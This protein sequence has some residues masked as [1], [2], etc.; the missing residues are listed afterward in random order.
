MTRVNSILYLNFIYRTCSVVT[1][2]YDKSWR[3]W[4]Y[5]YGHLYH[6]RVAI[7]STN[8]LQH[9]SILIPFLFFFFPRRE[10]LSRDRVPPPCLRAKNERTNACTEKNRRESFARGQWEFFQGR[11]REKDVFRHSIGLISLAY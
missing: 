8:A 5:R 7:G 9:Y 2:V 11:H 3:Q 1:Y 10:L 4:Q 6:D